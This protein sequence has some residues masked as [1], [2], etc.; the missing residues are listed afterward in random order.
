MASGPRPRG[1]CASGSRHTEESIGS[2]VNETNIDRVTAK[3]TV[4]PNCLKNRPMIP[5][6]KPTGR[7]TATMVKVVAATASPISAVPS[8]AACLWS[9][10]LAWW[11]TMFSR[12]TIASSISR[13][14]QI[15]SASSV[16]RLIVKPIAYIARK[17]PISE[18]G[19]V[20]PVMTVER[21]EERNRN[22]ISTVSAAPSKMLRS[23]LLTELRIA[24]DASR[25]TTSSTPGGSSACSTPTA[26]L[27]RSTTSIVFSPCALTRSSA[28][29]RWPSTSAESSR[30]SSPST[31]LATCDR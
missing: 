15:D 3:A 22:T 8:K 16:T 30:S 21:H 7:N 24:V 19:S 18:I 17:V 29:A 5:P 10:P 2:S 31:T 27:T 20:S 28:I 13:P 23:T 4:I 12:T 11:R 25:T 9:L 1:P 6:M 14:T 26:S